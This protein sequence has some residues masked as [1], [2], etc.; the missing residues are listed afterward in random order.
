MIVKSGAGLSV[1]TFW[2][3][4]RRSCG[5]GIWSLGT[6]TIT[7]II[8]ITA[9]LHLHLQISSQY[10]DPHLHPASSHLIPSYFSHLS[11]ITYYPSLRLVTYHSFLVPRHPSDP[12]LLTQPDHP[13]ARHLIQRD[14]LT[15]GRLW[16][17]RR[18]PAH[19]PGKRGC[20][21]RHARWI[22]RGKGGF[23]GVW[24]VPRECRDEGVR[25]GE[26]EG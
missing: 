15:P 20:R 23:E 11:P 19:P 2:R 24:V 5:T 22:G 12:C 25:G 26:S 3:M 18:A 4:G 6:I 13:P 16:S 8:T 17:R 9:H 14:N 7:I 1:R 21:G 10:H